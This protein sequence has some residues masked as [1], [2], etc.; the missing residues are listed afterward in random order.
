MNVL[1]VGLVI[2]GALITVGSAMIA[3]LRLE[4]FFLPYLPQSAQWW[5]RDL[6]ASAGLII[7]LGLVLRWL[8]PA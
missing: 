5:L 1:T 8:A 7:G 2:A 6:G 4:R 3:G